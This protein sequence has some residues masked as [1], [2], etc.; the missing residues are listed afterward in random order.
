M[1]KIARQMTEQNSQN[2]HNLP[3]FSVSEVSYAIKRTIEENFGYVRVRGEISGAKRAPSGHFY[4]SLKDEKSVLSAVCW[5]GVAATLS[6]QPEDGLEVIATGR[7]TAYPGRS[8]YQLVIERL[9]PA[10]VGA[11][12]ALLEQR[13]KQFAAEGLFDVARKKPIPFLPDVIGVVTSPTGAVIQ[14]ILHRLEERFPRKVLLWP[15]KVQG[16]GAAEEVAAA[17]RGFNQL[18][19][20]GGKYPRPDVLI[21]A[22]GGGSIEDLWA[23]NEECVVR[24][25]AESGIPVISAVGHETDTTLVDYVSDRRAPTPTGAAEMA[26]PVRAELVL[27]VDDLA[28][29]K[30]EAML[31]YFDHQ[32]RYVSNLAR[33]LPKPQQLLEEKTQRLDVYAERLERSLPVMF[34]QKQY[35]LAAIASRL[36]LPRAQMD[37]CQQKLEY[38][39]NRFAS[40]YTRFIE[41]KQQSLQLLGRMLESMDYKKILQRGYAV[42][43]DAKGSV[44][45]TAKQAVSEASLQIEFADGRCKVAPY[46]TDAPKT[47]QRSANKKKKSV[48]A[49]SQEE[50]F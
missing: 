9:E 30:K 1:N 43:T 13:K 29:R 22:R 10:G 36:V 15:V 33:L 45:T 37:A 40:A 18:S 21:V 17:I 48:K 25:V 26:V 32:K 20:E 19:G 46:D 24:A 50:L 39:C 34:S 5:K 27:L 6:C 49:S 44:V 16:D 38:T 23:F 28:R 11:L 42:I 35:Q 31:R 3:E 41:K 12:M 14:D 8:N 4:L 7:M 47:K 2:S